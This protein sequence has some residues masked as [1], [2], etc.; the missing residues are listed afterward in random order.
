M[1][2][3]GAA[4][5]AAGA[6][7]NGMGATGAAANGS[8]AAGAAA[9]K[10]GAAGAGGGPWAAGGGSWAAGARGGT[11]ARTTA[12][13]A[14]IRPSTN[15][16]WWRLRASGSWGRAPPAIRTACDAAFASSTTA[17]T[18]AGSWP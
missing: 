3:P 7:A 9:N 6:G 13:A 2:G 12:A 14:A 5:G 11:A 18:R 17:A 1:V 10:R 8:G 16:S 15:P 4:N